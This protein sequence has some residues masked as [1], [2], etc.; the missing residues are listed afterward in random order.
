MYKKTVVT[1]LLSTFSMAFDNLSLHGFGTLGLTYQ[2]DENI[3]YRNNWRSDSGSSGDISLQNDSKFGLQLDWQI[4]P[5]LSF[6]I[7]GS[8]DNGGANLEWANIK[9]NI[10]DEFDVKI[11]QMRFPTAMYSDILKVSYSYDWIRLPE[12]VYGILP[13][14]SYLGGEFNYQSVYKDF[15]YRFKLYAGESK[16]TMKG[17]VDVGDYDIELK[18]IFGLNLSFLFDN[19]EIYTGYTQ[20][21]ISITNDLINSYFDTLYKRDDLSLSQKNIL[22][23]YDPR[24]KD[25]KYISVGFKYTYDNAYLVGEYIDIDMKNIISDNYAWYVGM[26]YHFGEITPLITY[27]RVTGRSNYQ[28]KIGD[29]QIDRD[30]AQMAQITLTSQTHIT[31]GLRYDI[32]ENIALKAQYDHIKESSKGRGLSIH[33][34]IPYEA[35]SIDLFGLSMDFIF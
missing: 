31:L 5:S 16:D 24:G 26:G 15:E 14:T 11:G 32:R 12:D 19:L 28:T 23:E 21:D 29:T 20:A 6:T 17:S 10:T 3:I 9:Y 2:D 8:V 22:H 4:E 13:L 35:T 34:E 33:K 27:S 7:Q 25:T 18:H 30:L 1:L